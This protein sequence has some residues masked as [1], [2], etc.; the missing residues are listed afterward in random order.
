MCRSL[1]CNGS[2]IKVQK[3]LNSLFELGSFVCSHLI[4][5]IVLAIDLEVLQFGYLTVN[6]YTP[7]SLNVQ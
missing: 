6:T 5:S 1:P 2:L 7:Y 3:S 4:G